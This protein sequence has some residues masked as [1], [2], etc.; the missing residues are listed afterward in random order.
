MHQK[1]FSILLLCLFLPL[2][3]HAQSKQDSLQYSHKLLVAAFD[4]QL[5]SALYYIKNGASLDYE[6]S[7]GYTALMYAAQNE[8]TDMVKLLV[9]NGADLEDMD[10]LQNTVLMIAVRN[11]LFDI[12]EYL[13]FW[14]AKTNQSNYQNLTPLQFAVYNSDYYMADMLLH[15]GAEV[16]HVDKEG[17]SALHLA[18]LTGDTALLKLLITHKAILDST[19]EY[20]LTPLDIA[21]QNKHQEA[22][23]ILVYENMK[24]K[25]D[26]KQLNTWLLAAVQHDNPSLVSFLSKE[27]EQINFSPEPEE[28]PILWARYAHN[29]FVV[30]RLK[31]MGYKSGWKPFWTAIFFHSDFNFNRADFYS[32][33]NIG[34]AD[35]RYNL[36]VYMAFGTRY[37]RKFIWI[38]EGDQVYYQ[39]RERRNMINL[40]IDRRFY[41]FGRLPQLNLQA[42]FELQAHFGNYAGSNRKFEKYWFPTAHAG[43]RYELRPA[44]FHVKWQYI[45]WGIYQ[46]PASVITFGVGVRVDIISK[47]STY[48]FDWI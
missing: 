25:P 3:S 6:D 11:G 28:N 31:S 24:M 37:H 16:N 10:Y 1:V 23:A 17:S 4:N 32:T 41:P 43:L 14:G 45:N 36:D 47:P 21:L 33:W 48:K 20:G 30:R 7:N 5:D 27:I 40:V 8:H 39:F 26:S 46:V 38:P 22:V 34:F 18:A 9:H 19:N 2:A 13:C 42:G 12:A 44:Y 29:P 15:Y 35:D